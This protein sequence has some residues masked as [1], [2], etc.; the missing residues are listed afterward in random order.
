MRGVA[1]GLQKQVNFIP[2]LARLVERVLVTTAGHK[3]HTYKSWF[4]KEEHKMKVDVLLEATMDTEFEIYE[5]YLWSPTDQIEYERQLSEMQ[6]GDEW[7]SA[8][9]MMICD[10]DT[11]GDQMIFAPMMVD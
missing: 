9:C 6:L 11:S 8:T 2:I 10:R 1:L 4:A 3:E 7:D 5:Q